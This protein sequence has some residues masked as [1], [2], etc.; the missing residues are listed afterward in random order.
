MRRL[1]G[2]FRGNHLDIHYHP[3]VS[4]QCSTMCVKD[5]LHLIVVIP[6]SDTADERLAE[7]HG[8]VWFPAIDHPLAVGDEIAKLCPPEWGVLATDGAFHALT[9]IHK[10]TRWNTIKP[11]VY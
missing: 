1:V 5:D 11:S 4:N 6:F 3:H 2:F 7:E 9:K 10:A 8:V